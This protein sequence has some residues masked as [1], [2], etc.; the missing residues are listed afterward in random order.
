MPELVRPRFPIRGVGYRVHATVVLR[1]GVTQEVSVTVNA[2]SNASKE[3][4]ESAAR[5]G[6]RRLNQRE[7]R[8]GPI[9]VIKELETYQL[10]E[11]GFPNP[12]IDL[13]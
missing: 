9:A 1:G 5:E 13:T 6:I 4:I 7:W 12:S 2:F 8:Y 3:D 10:V 11:G